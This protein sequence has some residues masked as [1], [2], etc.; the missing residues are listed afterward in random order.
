MN[1]PLYAAACIRRENFPVQRPEIIDS[2]YH[3]RKKRHSRST[4]N[5][6]LVIPHQQVGDHQVYM[7]DGIEMTPLEL[8]DPNVSKEQFVRSQ[9]QV[10]N[11][12]GAPSEAAYAPVARHCRKRP[13]HVRRPLQR[14]RRSV[15]SRNRP[16]S[17][18]E[19]RA[20]AQA[21]VP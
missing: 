20:Q 11:P 14:H 1:L 6:Q 3:H 5:V 12:Q 8:S 18:A 4:K 9:P 2:S 16:L 19:L 17:S 13:R 7:R 10:I 21:S 15:R